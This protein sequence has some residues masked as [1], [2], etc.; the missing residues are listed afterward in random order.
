MMRQ[1]TLTTVLLILLPAVTATSCGNHNAASCELCPQGNGAGWC[2][3]EC[4]WDATRAVDDAVEGD[5]RCYHPLGE[6]PW[7]NC[8]AGGESVDPDAAVTASGLNTISGDVW[9]EATCGTTADTCV[10]DG[11]ESTCDFHPSDSTCR[12]KLNNRGNTRTASVHL[13][14][15]KPDGV[16]EGA[17]W[18]QR[19]VPQDV[20][21]VTYMATVG[22]NFGYGGVQVVNNGTGGDAFHGRVIFSI[23]DQGCDQD[24][25]SDCDPEALARTV[26][27]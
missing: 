12:Y 22:Q 2:N 1:D 18:F 7:R 14:P 4:S 16:A 20:A 19:V 27:W 6:A 5:E 9:C 17:W 11:P 15:R 3:G 24:F 25:Q 10:T 26:A 23:W 21:D 13:N 8:G